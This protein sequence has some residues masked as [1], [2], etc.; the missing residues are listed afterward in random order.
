MGSAPLAAMLLL[1]A[2]SSFVVQTLRGKN[3]SQTTGLSMLL[4]QRA[5]FDCMCALHELAIAPYFPSLLNLTDARYDAR[6][7][8]PILHAAMV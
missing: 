4:E 3:R 5:C 1:F 8:P 2:P 6:P 7:L